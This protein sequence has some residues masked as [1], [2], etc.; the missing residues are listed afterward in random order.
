MKVKVK[1]LNEFVHGVCVKI[2]LTQDINDD[3]GLVFEL[4]LNNI[5]NIDY[6][7]LVNTNF[8]ISNNVDFVTKYNYEYNMDQIIPLGLLHIEHGYA[9]SSSLTIRN[10]P[11]QELYKI[12]ILVDGILEAIKLKNKGVEAYRKFKKHEEYD[13]SMQNTY[14]ELM[15]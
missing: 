8:F 5:I 9:D 15:S 4:N 6:N 12:E 2:K 10:I 7:D 14:W 11:F 13:L 3:V 1:Y